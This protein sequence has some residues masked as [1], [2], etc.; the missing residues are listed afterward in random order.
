M[1]YASAK[2]IDSPTFDFTTLPISGPAMDSYMASLPIQTG[3]T[4]L[5]A[6]FDL[7][8]NID[9]MLTGDRIFGK[10]LNGVFWIGRTTNASNWTSDWSV[11]HYSLAA[12]LSG[13]RQ[14][15]GGSL[16]PRAVCIPYT[17]K[18]TE[19]PVDLLEIP[20]LRE[21]QITGLAF[22]IQDLCHFVKKRRV[23]SM[24]GEI[25]NSDPLSSENKSVLVACAAEFMR[26]GTSD[27]L[28]Q[29]MATSFGMGV[30]SCQC[31][32][33]EVGTTH[34][35]LIENARLELALRMLSEEEYS[36]TEIALEL[37]YSY[38]GHFTRFFKQKVGL[39]P[40]EYRKIEVS[41]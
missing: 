40:T 36:V 29:R 6:A 39:S 2:L 15:F 19:L 3:S 31:R 34:T 26:S 14:L 4:G 17:A 21:T 24:H 22:R 33:K 9:R 12:F 7:A 30:R 18:L 41:A 16:K 20:Q 37:G 5:D 28:A 32:L 10:V 35:E 38:P 23:Q 27:M 25:D 13:V 1:I 11:V 8:A